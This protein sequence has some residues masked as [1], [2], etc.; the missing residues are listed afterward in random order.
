MILHF[1]S[2]HPH[3]ED[4]WLEACSGLDD[5][6]NDDDTVDIIDDLDGVDTVDCLMSLSS[7]LDSPSADATDYMFYAIDV[8]NRFSFLSIDNSPVM[9]SS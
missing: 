5:T 3:L 4:D 8:C 2:L 7:S 9:E 6:S 1:W